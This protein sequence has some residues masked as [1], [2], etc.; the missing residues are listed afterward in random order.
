MKF[1]T[2]DVVKFVAFQGSIHEGP[3]PHSLH[4]KVGLLIKK[5]SRSISS[6]W[7]ACWLILV[8]QK[9]STCYERWMEMISESR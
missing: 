7:G 4:G 1:Q 2:G 5:V 6:D 3:S 9:Q 8:D